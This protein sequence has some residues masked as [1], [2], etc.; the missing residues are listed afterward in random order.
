MLSVWFEKMLDGSV[1][2]ISG[3][4]CG[5]VA[6]YLVMHKE[7]RKESKNFKEN[8]QSTNTSFKENLQSTNTNFKEVLQ[9]ESENFKENLQ[10]TNIN[11][12][13]V[14]Q[15]ESENFKE[16]LQKILDDKEKS[17]QQARDDF[18]V[19]ISEKEKIFSDILAQKD[20]KIKE[21]QQK[22]GAMQVAKIADDLNAKIQK[23]KKC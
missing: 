19:I 12:K 7:F 23:N 6:A 1:E 21:L 3:M 10:S 14:L 4:L 22:L 2:L 15:K 16:N 9:K 17:L 11:F 8:L 18:Q 20:A 5:F 13:E